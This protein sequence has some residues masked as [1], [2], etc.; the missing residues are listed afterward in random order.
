R[1]V[2]VSSRR[3]ALRAVFA[4]LRGTNFDVLYLNSFFHRRFTWSALALW[5]LR[6][7]RARRVVLAP[8]G[9]FSPGALGIHPRR[10]QLGIVAARVSLLH[11]R[12]EFQASNP[13]EERDIRAVFGSRSLVV[14]VAQDL[15]DHLVGSAAT[16][17][18]PLCAESGLRVVFLSRISPKKN[19]DGAIRS[20]LHC[21]ERVTLTIAGPAREQAYWDRCRGLMA[22]APPHVSIE[23]VGEVAPDEV[24]TFLAQA[25]VTL[26]PS[27]GENFGHVVAESL[28]AGTPVLISDRT[29]W[30]DVEE[31]GAGW[32]RSPDDHHGFAAVLDGYASSS[33]EDRRAHRV[34]ARALAEE[35]L[36]SGHAEEAHRRMFRGAD[37]SSEGAGAGPTGG[38]DGDHP[39]R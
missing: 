25:D 11:R 6:R 32:V 10:K 12:V 35:R 24:V 38:G 15:T 13:H 22:D 14:H 39:V 33:E 2:Y 34:A 28:M 1:V 26:L 20:V 18:V 21:T 19:L 36:L 23:H 4:G 7:I 16:T 30:S 17:D 5:A 3:G 31:A 29:P 8:R 27:Y 9:E 37:V